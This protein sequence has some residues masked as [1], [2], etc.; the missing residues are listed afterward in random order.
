MN[1]KTLF[2]ALL[3]LAVLLFPLT[4]H[5]ILRSIEEAH[6][7]VG[8][9]LLPTGNG[10]ATA[11]VRA[12][13]SCPVIKLRVTQKTRFIRDGQAVRF[14]DDLSLQGEAVDVFYREDG[15]ATRFEW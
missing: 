5:S 8:V 6:E 9:K 14:T 4:A 1:R 12:C 2:P 13:R 10:T 3:S 7:G 11:L 15:T